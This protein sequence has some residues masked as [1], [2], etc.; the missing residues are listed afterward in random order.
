M[1]LTQRAPRPD[2]PPAPDEV[3]YDET[4]DR[5]LA[6]IFAPCLALIVHLRSQTE[7]GDPAALRRRIKELIDQAERDAQ[8]TGVPTDHVEAATFAIVAFL[9]ET[10][11]SSSW[12]QKDHWVSR[13]LQRERYDRYDAGE[14]FF[15][16]LSA[17]LEHP[18]QHAEAIEI[19][20]LCMTLGFR[21]RY[22][23][24]QQ[25]KLQEY[26]DRCHD[27]LERTP[28]IQTDTLAPNGVPTDQVAAEMRTKLPRWII[29]VASVA[30]ALLLYVG[31]SLY[32]SYSAQQTADAVNQVIQQSAATP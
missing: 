29:P 2:A 24:V 22:Q 7:Y 28:G 6:E 19:Y 26:I 16:R 10:I 17:L 25:E 3:L 9:D 20:Y 8:R 5:R 15:E 31:L 13:P 18:T 32:A 4:T 12:S 30:L 23:I 11:L 1:N 21:G 14:V 27:E